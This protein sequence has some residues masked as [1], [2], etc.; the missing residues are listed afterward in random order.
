MAE[1]QPALTGYV[2]GYFNLG[3]TWRTFENDVGQLRDVCSFK[4]YWTISFPWK[5]L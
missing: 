4:R 1:I 5:T 3:I 2:R